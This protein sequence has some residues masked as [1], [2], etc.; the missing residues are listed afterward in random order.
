MAQ[1]S[2]RLLVV[3]GNQLFPLE[4]LETVQ[5]GHAHIQDDQIGPHFM[6]AAHASLS[7]MRNDDFKSF[8]F[9]IIRNQFCQNWIV[10]NNQNF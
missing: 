5:L 9:Q 6:K 7:V 10:I 3:L 4:H 1:S 8:T 2:S